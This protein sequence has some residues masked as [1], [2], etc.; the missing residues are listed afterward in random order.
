MNASEDKISA[1]D[2]GAVGE[3]GV[4]DEAVALGKGRMEVWVPSSHGL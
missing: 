2:R 1:V 3:P 4:A